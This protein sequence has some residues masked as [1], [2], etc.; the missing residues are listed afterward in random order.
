MKPQVSIVCITYNQEK[1]IKEA[2]DSFLMQKTNFP[3]DVIV[4]DDCSLDGTIDI[5]KE[6]AQK[7]PQIIK[8]VFREKNIG[9]M[10]NFI[11]ALSLAKSKYVIVNEGDDYFCDENKL[12][13]QFDFLEAHPQYSACFH[14]VKVIYENSS[15]CEIYPKKEMMKGKKEISFSDLLRCNYV[16]TNSIMYRWRFIS[17]NISCFIPDDILPGDWYLH[18]LHAQCGNFAFLNDVMAVY[19][20]HEMGIWWESRNNLEKLHLKHGVKEINFFYYVYKNLTNCDENYFKTVFSPS[21]Q[22]IVNILY[23]NRKFE[24]LQYINNSNSKIFDLIKLGTADNQ[25]INHT[26]N[27]I[28]KYRN[29][30]RCFLII[31]IVMAASVCILVLILL[32]WS[33]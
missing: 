18:L 24:D 19:R 16:Q 29:L 15:K 5:I 27:K 8:P 6:Y 11:S 21:V 30:F 7:Y 22:Y 9:T 31:S 3:F 1:F 13:K 32:I 28:K 14:P 17:E 20:R 12:Q 25:N 4:S 33:L 10:R 26:L 2:L 23:Q